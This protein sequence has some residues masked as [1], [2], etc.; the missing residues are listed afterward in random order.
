M[1]KEKDKATF[2]ERP[3]VV[4]RETAKE[5]LARMAKLGFYPTGPVRVSR[6]DTPIHGWGTK[7]ESDAWKAGK[8]AGAGLPTK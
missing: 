3:A 1:T 4:K 2:D 6:G 5:K 7:E 8:S